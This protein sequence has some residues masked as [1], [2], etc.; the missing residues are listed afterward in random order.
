VVVVAASGNGGGEAVEG[1]REGPLLCH[2]PQERKGEV[3]LSG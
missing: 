3:G 2:Q 1:G